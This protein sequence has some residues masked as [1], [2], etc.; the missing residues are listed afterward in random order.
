MAAI[1]AATVGDNC[2]DRYL[3]LAR[4][5]VGGNAVN[6]AVHLVRLGWGT[7][8][9]GAVGDDAEGRQVIAALEENGVEAGHVR[10]RRGIRTGTTD[11]TFGPGSERIIGHEDLGACADYRPDAAEITR[12]GRLR[13]VHIG[14]LDDGGAEG[15]VHISE[16]SDVPGFRPDQLVAPGEQVMVKVL[17]VERK[18][19]RLSLSVRRVLLDE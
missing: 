17:A 8:Y 9:F 11:I 3:P 6:V 7:A 19:R 12:L 4:A 10:I 2:I 13:H 1:I 15:L 16:L 18:K 5:T 14:W